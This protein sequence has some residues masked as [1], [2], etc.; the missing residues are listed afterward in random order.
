MSSITVKACELCGQ[1]YGRRP[2]DPPSVFARRRFC[3]PTCAGRNMEFTDHERGWRLELQPDTEDWSIETLSVSRLDGGHPITADT[4]RVIATAMPG[5]LSYLGRKAP[6]L[7]GQDEQA[8]AVAA[9]GE[10]GK[11]LVQVAQIYSQAVSEGNRKPVRAVAEDFGYSIATANRWI[12]QAR[13]L[14]LLPPSGREK[15]NSDA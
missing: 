6:L 9:S 1:E 3:S 4:L 2:T 12:R 15:G 7:G 8:E 11:R 10:E 13:D 5:L 14:G